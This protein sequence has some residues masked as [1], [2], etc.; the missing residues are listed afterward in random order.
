MEAIH[1]LEYLVLPTER[2]TADSIICLLR[3]AAEKRIPRV[4]LSAFLDLPGK[5][6]T[7]NFSRLLRYP[8]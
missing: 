1:R 8:V 3:N 7:S 5:N 4:L 2:G 6:I